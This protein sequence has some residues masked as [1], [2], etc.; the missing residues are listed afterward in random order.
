M[1]FRITA[2]IITLLGAA[3]AAKAGDYFGEDDDYFSQ[4]APPFKVSND[5]VQF[6]ASLGAMFIEGNE[7]VFDGDYRLS[8]LIWQSKVPVL[9][10]SLAVRVGNGFSIRADGSTAAFGNSFI[11]DY[12]W[13]GGSDAFNN[14]THRSQHPDTRLDHYF[15]GSLSGAYDLFNDGQSS[16]RATA[17]VEYTD[18]K[19]TAYGGSY[20]YS[21]GG[22]RDTSGTFADGVAVGD[23]RQQFPVIF[24]GFDGDVDFGSVRWGGMLRGGVTV[25]PRG[26]DNHFLRDLQF[27]DYLSPAPTFALGTDIGFKVGEHAEVT[28]AARYD[29]IIRQRGRTE[30]YQISNG[31]R[32]TVEPDAGAGDFHSLQLTGGLKGTF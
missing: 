3:G 9:R 16:V 7:Y 23:Y 2:V 17:G 26:T 24:G 11:E 12:D 18:V 25:Y 29:Q 14:W 20:L 6:G 1:S 27:I 22:F 19:W 15:T 13:L 30:I 4:A 32:L 21:V 28:I 5:T 8:Q 10:G 31:N